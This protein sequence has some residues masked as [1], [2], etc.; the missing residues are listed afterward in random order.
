MHVMDRSRQRRH[1]KS[2]TRTPKFWLDMAVALRRCEE[3]P[4]SAALVFGAGV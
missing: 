1:L 4:C 2:E 3:A